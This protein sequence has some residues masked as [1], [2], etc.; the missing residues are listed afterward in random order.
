MFDGS[1]DEPSSFV[2]G[3]DIQW[4]LPKGMTAAVVP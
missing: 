4:G 2:D 3:I 1:E